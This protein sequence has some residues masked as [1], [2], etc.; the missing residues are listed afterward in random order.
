MKTFNYFLAAALTLLVVGCSEEET[1][2][3][4]QVYAPV[5]VHVNDF[6]MSVDDFSTRAEETVANYT[7]VGAITLA[8]YNSDGAQQ[9]MTTQLRS[10]ASTYTTFGNFSCDLPVGNYTMVVIGRGYFDGDAFTLTSPTSA[11]YTS[12]RARETF[13]AKQDVTVTSSAPLAL[14]VTLSRIVSYIN[15]IST[16]GRA[17]GVAKIRTTYAKGSKSFNPSTGFATDDAG[18]ALTNTPSAAIGSPINVGSFVFLTTDE[19]TMNITI[20]V[21]D[22]SNNVLF[23]KVVENVPLKRNRKTTLT[24]AMFTAPSSTAA[25]QVDTDWLE[26]NSVNF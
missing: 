24:G 2:N 13:V 9:Y 23:T 20:E 6:S 14:N 8:F 19:E 4:P 7:D 12:E 26:G 3:N 10:D 5:T 25:F 18:F 22:A 16:D 11:G 17:T 1:G 15:I 21:L